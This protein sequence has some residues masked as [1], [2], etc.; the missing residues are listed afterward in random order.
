MTGKR[1]WEGRLK[2]LKLAFAPA[3]DRDRA[4]VEFREQERIRVRDEDPAEISATRLELASLQKKERPQVDRP[5]PKPPGE[6]ERA[7]T[8]DARSVSEARR[9]T[10]VEQLDKH[11]GWRTDRTGYDNGRHF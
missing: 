3:A 1:E 6:V 9:Q 11:D 8:L 4:A 2:G 5:G 10:L 7:S